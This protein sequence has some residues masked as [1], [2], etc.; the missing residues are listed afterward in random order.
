MTAATLLERRG[1]RDLSDLSVLVGGAEDW[2]A[3]TGRR[4]EYRA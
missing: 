2:S 3:A 4:L 1:R